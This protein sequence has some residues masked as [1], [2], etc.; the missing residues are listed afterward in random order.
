MLFEKQSLVRLGEF[1]ENSSEFKTLPPVTSEIQASHS[2]H[3]HPIEQ[4]SCPCIDEIHFKHTH[5]YIEVSDIQYHPNELNIQPRDCISGTY[6]TIEIDSTYTKKKQNRYQH[7]Q[8]I[9]RFQENIK[10]IAGFEK[11]QSVRW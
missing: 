11:A 7:S 8:N 4:F 1:M 9:C 5:Y 2:D 6:Q 10:L 3:T